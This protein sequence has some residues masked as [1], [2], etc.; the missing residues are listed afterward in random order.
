MCILIWAL[1]I[2]VCF[3]RRTVCGKWPST[4]SASAPLK[5]GRQYSLP[6]G[7]GPRPKPSRITSSITRREGAGVGLGLRLRQPSSV[8]LVHT[9][10]LN[11]PPCRHYIALY[12]EHI[13]LTTET[14]ALKVLE[15]CERHQLK[16]QGELESHSGGDSQRLTVTA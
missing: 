9:V 13:P 7:L 16:E 6:V 1:A 10:V 12:I 15:V 4:T 11:W 14:K 8:L 3:T 2:A 5:E